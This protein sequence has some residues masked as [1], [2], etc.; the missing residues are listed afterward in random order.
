MN[1]L[2]R[3]NFLT[4]VLLN[5][6]RVQCLP[7]NEEQVGFIFGTRDLV[8]YRQEVDSGRYPAG[9]RPIGVQDIWTVYQSHYFCHT[10]NVFTC[11][12]S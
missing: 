4:C 11:G 9:L 6:A 2:L 10:C 3:S 1:N 7:T 5:V 12:D 8:V